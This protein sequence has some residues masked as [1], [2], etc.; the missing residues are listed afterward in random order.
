MTDYRELLEAIYG[1]L[2]K[3]HGLIKDNEQNL[4]VVDKADSLMEDAKSDLLYLNDCIYS[5][6]TRPSNTSASPPG[7]DVGH[8]QQQNTKQPPVTGELEEEIL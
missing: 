4:R 6:M 5:D 3:L 8:N 7:S 2:S 1:N